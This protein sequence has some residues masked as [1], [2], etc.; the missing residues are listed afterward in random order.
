MLQ[1][2]QINA[3]ARIFIMLLWLIFTAACGENDPPSVSHVSGTATPTASVTPTPTFTEPNDVPGCCDFGPTYAG[4][5]P[6]CENYPYGAYCEYPSDA[7]H[8]KPGW[9]CN[10]AA[11][12]C[13]P[14]L[15]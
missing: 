14:G 10:A 15:N 5:P 7:T 2:Y 9:H 3:L 1:R 8:F 6:L 11:G 12:H 13:E 4:Q